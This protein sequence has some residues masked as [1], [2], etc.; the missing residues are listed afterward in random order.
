MRSDRFATAGSLRRDGAWPRVYR[1]S[2]GHRVFLGGLGGLALL[3]GIA[4]AA[5]V[6]L[7]PPAGAPGW[8]AVVPVAF[9]LLGAYLLAALVVERVVLHEEAIEFVEL[10]RGRRRLR[11]DEIAGRRVFPL[12]YGMEQLV[13]ELRGLGRKPFKVSLITE[14]DEVLESWLASIPD[15]DAEDRRREEEE[16]LRSA[17]LG[18]TEDERRGALAGARRIARAARITAFAAAAWG[19]FHP[20]PYGPAMAAL[21]II[22]AAALAV[23]VVGRG[24]YS[25]EGRRNEVRPELMTPILVPAFVLVLR[26]LLDLEIVDH[27]PLL[28]WAALGT[29]GIGALLAAS[30]PAL[31]RRVPALALLVALVAAYPWA[32]LA[33]ANALLDRSPRETFRVTVVGKHVST[34]KHTSY[35]LR[36]A[37]WGPVE[38]EEDADVGRA[39]YEAVA[40]GDAVC[41]LLRGGALGVRWYVVG[42]CP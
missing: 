13:L 9:A 20:R 23:L 29:L 10:G 27:R 30:D 16:L 35:E 19:W 6:L 41:A 1:A 21:A 2:R 28:Q 26:V 18:R 7:R 8:L 36:L 11:R 38:E 31:R 33:Q 37:P 25:L 32:L 14:R 15:V 5:L 34:G 24:R 12:Q 3:G 40:V 42:R 22:P 39:T 4:G 17:E